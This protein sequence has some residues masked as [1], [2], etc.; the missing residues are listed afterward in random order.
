MDDLMKSFPESVPGQ[1]TLK[2]SVLKLS[3]MLQPA[4]VYRFLIKIIFDQVFVVN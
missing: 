1:N 4:H 3:E 2:I